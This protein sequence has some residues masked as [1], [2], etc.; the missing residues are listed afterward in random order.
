MVNAVRSHEIMTYKRCPKKWYWAWRKGLV[1]K[2][3][4]FGALDLG[5][6]MHE[7]LANWYFKGF[8][9]TGD[10]AVLFGE[11]ANEAV[12]LAQENNVPEWEIEKAEELAMLGEA[13]ADSYQE[14]YQKTDPNV[15]VITAEIPLEFT[16]DDGVI[17]KMKPDL[18]YR[19]KRDQK[20]RLMEHK[21]AGQIRTGHLTID[22]QARPYGAL[23]ERAL[24]NAGV[25]SK[26]E[27]IAGIT[28]NFLRKAL[29]DKRP[30]NEQGLYLNKDGTPSK[31]QPNAQF[32]RHEVTLSKA[33]KLVALSRIKA[34]A[35]LVT[36]VAQ[37]LR[38]GRVLPQYLP[39][40]PDKS[41]PAT[42]EFFAMC[43][44]EEAGGDYKA[45]ERLQFE[46]RDPYVYDEESTQDQAG[47]DVA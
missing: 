8:E 24:K 15:D 6:W 37:A 22:G 1:P 2:N 21:T 38:E 12:C 46:R 25:L 36:G 14:F 47:F 13:V 30:M 33:A 42:C 35:I 16:L 27:G 7:A 23:A 41:C 17:Y 43:E 45:M 11:F 19:S 20:I 4:R 18:I 26:A 32:V 34:D 10:L 39:K 44:V 40:T 3:K 31:S 28:Y 29:P 9:R 5:T